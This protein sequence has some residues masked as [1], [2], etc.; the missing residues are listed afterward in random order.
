MIAEKAHSLIAIA[1]LVL[2]SKT[3]QAIEE[4]RKLYQEYWTTYPKS[5]AANGARFCYVQSYVESGERAKA[6]TLIEKF[7]LDDP[8]WSLAAT[9]YVMLAG[10]FRTTCRRRSNA[11]DLAAGHRPISGNFGGSPRL[12]DDRESGQ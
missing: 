8:Q 11:T 2:A 5:L 6:L 12:G 10:E 7:R 4:A 9:A 1:Q 3:P